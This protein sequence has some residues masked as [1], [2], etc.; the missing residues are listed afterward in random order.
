MPPTVV[1]LLPSATEIVAALGVDPAATSHEC[2]YPP[3]VADTPT[4]V[5][6]RIDADADSETIDEQVHEAETDG[7]VYAIDRETLAAVD[8]D[9]VISQGIC[10]VCAVDTVQVE[11]AIADLGL[12]CRLVTTD[13]HSVDDILGDIERIGAALGKDRRANRLA[14]ALESRM[15]R[16]A[17][18]TAGRSRRPTVAVLDWLSPPMVAGHWVPE[19]VERAGGEYGLAD[20]GDASMPREW[21][22]IREYDPDV[23]VAAPCGFDL[24]QTA[25]NRTDLTERP[26]WNDLRAVRNGRVYAMDGHHL[27]NR[28][29]IRVL[30][31]LETLAALCA[32]TERDSPA[33]WMARPLAADG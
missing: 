30:E 2:D 9:I 16:V 11:A 6:S 29:G 12:D 33:P 1:S 13:P 32:P 5:E 25:D 20:P 18:R 31:T 24:E 22:T 19:L 4:V 17:D 15:D 14:A 27:T 21:A 26:G 10:E 8:P 23:L 7:G 28:P 3:S